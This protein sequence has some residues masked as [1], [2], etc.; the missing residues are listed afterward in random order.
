MSFRADGAKILQ[1]WLDNERYSPPAPA[2]MQGHHD[3]KLFCPQCKEELG[4]KFGRNS[5]RYIIQHFPSNLQPRC[6]LTCESW[7]GADRQE[8]LGV[9]MEFSYA[10]RS[11][12]SAEILSGEDPATLTIDIEAEPV[13]LCDRA[14]PEGDQGG[15]GSSDDINRL[16]ADA[17]NRADEP[18]VWE[19]I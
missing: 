11:K 5:R 4:A 16:L 6:P 19:E 7:S 9:F 12:I 13:A 14:E 18:G 8:A 2:V 17:G 15:E 3:P 1:Q 10:Y